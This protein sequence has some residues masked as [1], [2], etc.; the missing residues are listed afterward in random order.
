MQIYCSPGIPF[1]PRGPGLALGLGAG[2]SCPAIHFISTGTTTSKSAPQA[3]LGQVAA[4]S[5]CSQAG[6]LASFI[7]QVFPERLHS[8]RPVLALE[9]ERRAIGPGPGV[10]EALPAGARG[11]NSKDS[12]RHCHSRAPARARRCSK[13]SKESACSTLRPPQR[14]GAPGIPW[15]GGR[16]GR[17]GV[18]R[19][20]HGAGP[21]R[22]ALPPSAAPGGRP[23]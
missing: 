15:A 2:S 17:R 18:P 23:T 12:S 11:G 19:A 6:W 22:T 3:P 16:R 21:R 9:I 8:A 10:H 5:S 14:A 4:W 13:R 20:G 1:R 7:Q